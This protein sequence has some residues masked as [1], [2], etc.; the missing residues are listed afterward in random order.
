MELKPIYPDP[1]LI[2]TLLYRGV[3]R[4]L[5]VECGDAIP[6]K[7]GS[8]LCEG[9]KARK[10]TLRGAHVIKAQAPQIRQ[11]FVYFGAEGAPSALG[12]EETPS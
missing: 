11:A 3:R 6:R 7:A 1:A 9:C 8:L 4:R 5:C 10:R 2:E 12:W